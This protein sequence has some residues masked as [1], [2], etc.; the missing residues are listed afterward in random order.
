MKTH[1]IFHIA[2]RSYPFLPPWRVSRLTWPTT[3]ALRTL[4]RLGLAGQGQVAWDGFQGRSSPETIVFP[5]KTMVF[6]MKTMVFP[7]KWWGFSIKKKTKPIHW[8]ILAQYGSHR[9]T[10]LVSVVP[11]ILREQLSVCLGLRSSS[12][13]CTFA[14]HPYWWHHHFWVQF[15]SFR[16]HFWT[17][18][19]QMLHIHPIWT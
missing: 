8:V 19:H 2:S 13:F 10:R 18:Y 11:W 15:P 6:P 17:G 7:M 1:E 4:T 5:M 16:T 14:H 12:D 9:L 3:P